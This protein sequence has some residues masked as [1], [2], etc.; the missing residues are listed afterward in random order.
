MQHVIRA[1]GNA[2]SNGGGGDSRWQ[3]WGELSGKVMVEIRLKGG[4]A[5]CEDLGGS[6]RWKDERAE[7]LRDEE[8]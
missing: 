3:W 7:T 5:A 4:D 2:Q 6:C 8:D 1:G